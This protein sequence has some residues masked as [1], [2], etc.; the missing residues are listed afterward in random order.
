MVA[1]SKYVRFNELCSGLNCQEIYHPWTPSCLASVWDI[2]QCS[3]KGSV[4]L[5]ASVYVVSY[6]SLSASIEGTRCLF[7][8]F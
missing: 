7:D 5:F 2:S 1:A 6:F 3:M 8:G 4:Y